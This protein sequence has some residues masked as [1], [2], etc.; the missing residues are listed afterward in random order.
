MN[1]IYALFL[2]FV[3]SILV[4]CILA[5]GTFVLYGFAHFLL[6]SIAKMEETPSVESINYGSLG[7]LSFRQ[8]VDFA[9]DV[10]RGHQKLE[11]Q[12]IATL[13]ERLHEHLSHE[14]DSRVR[15][16]AARLVRTLIKRLN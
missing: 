7:S 15:D 16:E 14:P 11:I 5:F 3:G 4:C 12:Q 13:V 1:I 6:R 10:D 8:L 2:L 9:W